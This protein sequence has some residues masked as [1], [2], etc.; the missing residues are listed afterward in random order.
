[1][2]VWYKPYV[3]LVWLGA[4]LM[5]GAGLLSLSYRRFRVGAP[6]PATQRAPAE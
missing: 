6:R 1:V 2:R 3:T 4:I 5:A